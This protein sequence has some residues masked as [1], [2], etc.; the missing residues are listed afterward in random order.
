MKLKQVAFILIAAILCGCQSDFERVR[1]PDGE[2][3]EVLRHVD[4]AYPVYAK[5]YD[6]QITLSLGAADGI[7]SNANVDLRV[8]DAVVKFREDLDQKRAFLQDELKTAVIAMN[9]APCDTNTRN[10]MQDLLLTISKQAQE[11]ALQRVGLSNI[12]IA[13]ESKPPSP[14]PQPTPAPQPPPKRLIGPQ[15]G[16][17]NS[18][19]RDYRAEVPLGSRISQIEIRICRQNATFV[20]GFEVR[21]ESN[22]SYHAGGD[23][24][25]QVDIKTLLLSPDERILGIYG[26][27]GGGMDSVN[28]VTSKS[29]SPLGRLG[30]TGGTRDFSLMA[31]NGYHIVGFYGRGGEGFDSI[32]IIEEEDR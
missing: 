27:Y 14:T 5:T 30:G 21:D 6:D 22:R 7:I 29:S 9:S 8:K 13:A 15:A 2:I 16:N 25:S 31:S 26:R 19:N 3:V 1:C 24:T 32:G 11:L 4:R 17:I 23:C 12:L 18:G 10:R 20:C 28:F